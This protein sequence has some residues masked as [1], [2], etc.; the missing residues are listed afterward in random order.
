MGR[1]AELVQLAIVG[2]SSGYVP[3]RQG[4][5]LT[6]HFVYRRPADCFLGVVRR[7]QRQPEVQQRDT[8]NTY[9]ALGI[10]GVVHD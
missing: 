9:E 2:L 1:A 7:S 5:T 3:E 4:H 8:A 10:P 6:Q